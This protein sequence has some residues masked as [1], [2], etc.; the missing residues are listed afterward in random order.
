MM[1]RREVLKT[2]STIP[3]AGGLMSIEPLVASVSQKKPVIDAGLLSNP[4]KGALALGPQ[5]YQSIGV[6][7]LINCRG[8]LSIIS[9]STELY[10][11]RK[12]VEYAAMLHVH[13]DEL[14]MAVGK[15]LAEI[16]GAEWGMVSSGCAAGLKHV[17]VACLTG[18]DPEKLVKIPDLTGFDKTEV[19]IPRYS[20]NQYDAAIRNTGADLIEVET[21]ED[22]KKAINSRT[23][24]IYL[25]SG[26]R[27]YYDGPLSIEKVAPVAREN[28]I[29]VLVD[30][31]A[32]ILTV[33]ND[34]LKWGATIVAYS[35]GKALRGPQ[36]AGL[37]LGNKDILF[38]TWQSSSPH[39]GPGRDNKIGKEEHMGMLAAVEAWVK[40]DHAQ[41]EKTWITWLEYI[42]KKVST[43]KGVTTQITEP[44]G[45]DNRSAR[46]SIS[47]DPAVL[48]ITGEEVSNELYNNSPRV[49]LGGGRTNPADG[50]T[51]ILI[52]A[53]MM[54][55]GDEKIVA[56]RI[57]NI[58]SAKHEKKTVVIEP[59]AVDISGQWDVSI[60]F[61]SGKGEH[62]LYLGKQEGHEIKGTHKS[63]FSLLDIAGRVEGKNVKL[64]SYYRENAQSIPYVF[65]G[66]V[67][68][69]TFSGVLYLGEYR[70]ASFVAKRAEAGRRPMM[71]ITIPAHGGRKSDS[72]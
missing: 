57:F 29:P 67:E 3:V 50:R 70:S 34:H 21:V 5:L 13:I 37:L 6:E 26:P 24:M 9:G 36:G 68:G 7:P 31:A 52:S 23:A 59:P 46:M 43:V 58:L 35:G 49:A 19:I 12:A 66:N 16:T 1:K 39:H 42:S 10:E 72:W 14:A 32:E 69:D 71:P 41:K 62:K 20:R 44:Q 27:A 40:T 33:P 63:T 30:A 55:P 28:N 4:A 48:N 8:T 61:Y 47:W 53:Q 11:V 22:L 54:Q 65:D 18:G 25:F 2:L 45:V 64:Q 38:S 56:D 15:R 51:S 17:T 60:D